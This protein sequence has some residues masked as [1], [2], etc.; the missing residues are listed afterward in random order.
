[1]SVH[2]LSTVFLVFYRFNFRYPRVDPRDSSS[3]PHS[4]TAPMSSSSYSRRHSVPYRLV[5]LSFS[6]LLGILLPRTAICLFSVMSGMHTSWSNGTFYC[7]RFSIKVIRL[8][9]TDVITLYTT[10]GPVVYGSY[11]FVGLK[12]IGQTI[13]V[14]HTIR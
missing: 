8:M 7:M 4:A 1:M 10:F 12:P 3:I 6:S 2:R 14:I 13:R 9:K 5:V 11:L